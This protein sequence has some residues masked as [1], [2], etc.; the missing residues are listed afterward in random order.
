MSCLVVVVVTVVIVKF[1]FSMLDFLDSPKSLSSGCLYVSDEVIGLTQSK[2]GQNPHLI[3][4]CP[5]SNM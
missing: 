3:V 5:K 1:K 2:V 4:N